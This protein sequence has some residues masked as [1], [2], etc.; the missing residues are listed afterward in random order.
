[1]DKA[2]SSV[3]NVKQFALFEDANAV[4]AS[5]ARLT[6]R[7]VFASINQT[8]GRYTSDQK[9]F[10]TRAV[11]NMVTTV[12]R[13]PGVSTVIRSNVLN[14]GFLRAIIAVGIR[15]GIPKIRNWLLGTGTNQRVRP[16][17]MLA[18]ITYIEAEIAAGRLFSEEGKHPFDIRR[19]RLQ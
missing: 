7:R 8:V 16:L 11:R 17:T 18:I 6:T 4:V 13:P 1:M 15:G 9:R 10:I 14:P 19:D 3:A 12:T 2:A 5:R